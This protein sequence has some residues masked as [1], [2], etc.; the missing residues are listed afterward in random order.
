M[1]IFPIKYIQDNTKNEKFPDEL[2]P[3]GDYTELGIVTSLCMVICLYCYMW[4]SGFPS[5]SAVLILYPLRI[6]NISATR[7]SHNLANILASKLNN[8]FTSTNMISYSDTRPRSIV[9]PISDIP[10]CK[11][12]ILWGRSH[13]SAV[14]PCPHLGS[15]SCKILSLATVRR[16]RFASLAVPATW[17]YVVRVCSHVGTD[18]AA[19]FWHGLAPFQ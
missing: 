4:I 11:A 15:N 16:C 19:F 10:D 13:V 5:W 8:I 17:E 6:P 3:G 2:L 14:K 7:I 9:S 18:P 1:Y 12:D